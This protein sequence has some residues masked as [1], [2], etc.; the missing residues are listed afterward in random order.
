MISCSADWKSRSIMACLI[1]VNVGVA[2]DCF[3]NHFPGG[4]EASPR[5]DKL[6]AQGR[7]RAAQTKSGRER[8]LHKTGKLASVTK[9]VIDASCPSSNG[10]PQ[11]G[12]N[13]CTLLDPLNQINP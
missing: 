10:E 13:I 9:D 1:A 3:S 7:K 8:P 5:T 12:K 6:F 11:A 4:K 2:E